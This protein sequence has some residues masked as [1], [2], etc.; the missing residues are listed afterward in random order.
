[1][2]FSLDPEAILETERAEHESFPPPSLDGLSDL[3]FAY[4]GNAQSPI[5]D[6]TLARV[7]LDALLDIHVL[8]DEYRFEALLALSLLLD[9]RRKLDRGE[10]QPLTS[11]GDPAFDKMPWPAETLAVVRNCAVQPPSPSVLFTNPHRQIAGNRIL[12]RWVAGQMLDSALYR[13]IAA[14]DRLAIML[15]CRSGHPLRRNSKN[16]LQAP[17]FTRDELKPLG[18]FFS[19]RPS[20]AN[21]RELAV[22]PLFKFAKEERNGFTHHRR[23]PSE[24]HGE[25]AVVYGSLSGGAEEIVEPIDARSHYAIAAAFYN[26]VLLPAIE[27]TRLTVLDG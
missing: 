22:H 4:P 8:V 1:M 9:Y 6:E 12:S 16:E 26:E 11:S 13:G 10:A 25:K 27:A 20:W 14:C 5:E 21:V 3:I 2:T 7:Y 18:Q 24:L 15:H 23:R 19:S 17:S